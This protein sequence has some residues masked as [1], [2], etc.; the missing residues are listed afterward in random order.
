VKPGAGVYT[1]APPW[2]KPSWP[3]SGCP[4]ATGVAPAVAA[5]SCPGV[6]LRGVPAGVASEAPSDVDLGSGAGEHDAT[7]NTDASTITAEP[8]LRIAQH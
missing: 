1:T 7:A 4:K 2:P 5:S 8:P 6:M 3:C